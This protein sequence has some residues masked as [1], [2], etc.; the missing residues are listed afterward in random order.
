MKFR[1]P[2]TNRQPL[3][4]TAPQL[5]LPA[6]AL[7]FCLHAVA[8]HRSGG[9]ATFGSYFFMIL[10]PALPAAVCVR[11]GILLPHLRARWTLAAV[12]FLFMSTGMAVSAWA[13]LVAHA[14][15]EVAFLSD[16]F[17]FFYG[18][19]LLIS[20][21][22]TRDDLSFRFSPWIDA[23]QSILAG[24]LVYTRIFS[25]LPF[26]HEAMRPVSVWTL[27][28]TYRIEDVLLAGVATL[29]VFSL[30]KGSADRRFTRIMAI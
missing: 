27:I 17:F 9:A 30:P 22:L 7:L 13:D 26:T 24:I 2:L 12:A 18:V 19:P 4:W 6:A 8:L 15:R 11:R 16:F 23:V 5:T 3:S 1:W 21:T 14:S 10:A 25:A 28:W 20:V 29:R